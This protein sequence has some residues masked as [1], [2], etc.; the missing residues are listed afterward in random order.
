MIRQMYGLNTQDP[1]T[2]ERNLMG[3][4]TQLSE[5]L[6]TRLRAS[7]AHLF[8]EEEVRQGRMRMAQRFG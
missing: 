1:A 7:W 3:V 6:R 4:D 5:G 8:K 2:E